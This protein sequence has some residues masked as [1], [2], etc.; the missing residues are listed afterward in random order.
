[1]LAGPIPRRSQVVERLHDLRWLY[2]VLASSIAIRSIV[3][4]G[5]PYPYSLGRVCPCRQGAEDLTTS[6][7]LSSCSY[8]IDP[9]SDTAGIWHNRPMA[10]PPLAGDTAPAV[11]AMQI[12]GWRR[13]TPTEKAAVITG[14]TQ[15][16]FDLALAGVLQRYPDASPHEQFL[17]RAIVIYGRE[18]AARAYPDIDVLGLE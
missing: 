6:A 11:E 16:T 5:E 15:T 1:M 12:D 17:R 10:R 7:S 2:D 18:L 4:A 8:S 9:P 14:L 13:M 3:T